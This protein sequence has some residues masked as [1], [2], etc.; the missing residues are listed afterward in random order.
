MIKY[1]LS[2]ANISTL[3]VFCDPQFAL[4]VAGA[5]RVLLLVGVCGGAVGDGAGRDRDQEEGTHVEENF[6][7]V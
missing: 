4:A 2:V 6:I 3:A 7:C 5:E 1:C